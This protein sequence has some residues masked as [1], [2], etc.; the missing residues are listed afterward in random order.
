MADFKYWQDHP[1]YI[2]HNL[3]VSK[4]HESGNW[5]M[6]Q[7]SYRPSIHFEGGEFLEIYWNG[8]HQESF[9]PNG[10]DKYGAELDKFIEYWLD[11][12]RG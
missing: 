8:D 12:N 11:E 3:L 6:F 9:T 5:E 2:S 4:K 1:A 10:T 7:V